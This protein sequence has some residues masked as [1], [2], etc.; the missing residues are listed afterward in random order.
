MRAPKEPGRPQA[1]PALAE[2]HRQDIERGID[3]LAVEPMI[4]IGEPKPP[5]PPFKPAPP[6]WDP[7]YVPEQDEP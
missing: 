3:P 7:N 6:P 2:L 1:S 5:P 4:V